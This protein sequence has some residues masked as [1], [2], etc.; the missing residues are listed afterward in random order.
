MDAEDGLRGGKL[1]LRREGAVGPAEDGHLGVAEGLEHRAGVPLRPMQG[2][3][4]VARDD[5]HKLDLGAS[6]RVGE[7][8]SVID[9]GV[10]IEYQLLAPAHRAA[11]TSSAV[12]IEG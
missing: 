8:Q 11:P 4:A 7:R 2:H 10:K 12:G 6:E 3:V 1:P 5:A 9:A